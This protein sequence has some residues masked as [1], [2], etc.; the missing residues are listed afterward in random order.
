MWCF[1]KSVPV[2]IG[3]GKKNKLIMI[4]I[5]TSD[6]NSIIEFARTLFFKNRDP[7]TSL[8]QAACT[9]VNTVYNEFRQPDQQPT[10]ALVRICRLTRS[11]EDTTDQPLVNELTRAG[12][13]REQIIC[14]YIGESLP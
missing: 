8:E 13:P 12:I 1:L 6:Q 9:I 11:D 3:L 7:L 10:F 14:T 2:F 4:S 5:K